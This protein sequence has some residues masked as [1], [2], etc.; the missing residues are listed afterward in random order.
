ML[1]SLGGATVEEAFFEIDRGLAL[2]PNNGELLY[3]AANTALLLG[4]L[5]RAGGYATT[6]LALYPKFAPSRAQLGYVALRDGRMDE[7]VS[8]LS[9]A[10]GAAWP[11][12]QGDR[13]AAEGNL[14]AALL[15]TGHSNDALPHARR[16]VEGAPSAPQ[17][18]FDLG[19]ALE[20]SA[21]KGEA[22]GQR[23]RE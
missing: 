21:E 8:L 14:A 7:A 22:R 9:A 5:P 3:D 10:L 6:A 19:R 1:S 4:E 20:R 18:R 15:Q 12:H 11:S 13:V 2:D 16:A 17:L 23:A